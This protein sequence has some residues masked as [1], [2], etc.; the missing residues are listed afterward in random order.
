[1]SDKEVQQGLT[2]SE[3]ARGLQAQRKRVEGACSVCGS[4]IAGIQRGGELYRQYC[5]ARCQ[6]AAYRARIKGRPT[7]S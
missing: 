4:A 6:K 3:L 7:D 1:M 5:S 2:P